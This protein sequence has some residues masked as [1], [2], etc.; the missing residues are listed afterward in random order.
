MD[1][2]HIQR[3]SGAFMFSLPRNLVFPI[4]LFATITFLASSCTNVTDEST[5][6]NQLQQKTV[7][8]IDGRKYVG[9]I[10][11]G[12]P[13]GKGTI[14]YPH[15]IKYTGEWKNGLPNGH[16][17]ITYPQGSEYVGEFKDGNLVGEGEY[18]FADAGREGVSIS[19]S[20]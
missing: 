17:T 18:H 3:I 14:Y 13:H 6:N 10:K 15:G 9:E 8:F 5:S 4:I 12:K 1:D 11:D 16:G 7:T 2:R 20:N 19:V